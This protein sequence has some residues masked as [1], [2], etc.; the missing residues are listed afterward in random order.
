MSYSWYIFKKYGI[1]NTIKCTHDLDVKW[2]IATFNNGN[3]FYDDLKS[4]LKFNHKCNKHDVGAISSNSC[5]PY[6]R[7]S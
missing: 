1:Y 6:S 3:C 4:I 5:Q 7:S 2:T